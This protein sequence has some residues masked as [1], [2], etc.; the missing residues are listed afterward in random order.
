MRFRVSKIVLSSLLVEKKNLEMWSQNEIMYLIQIC[1]RMTLK[2]TYL[3]A[4]RLI[5]IRKSTCFSPKNFNNS[6]YSHENSV[7]SDEKINIRKISFITHFLWLFDWIFIF[8]F[9]FWMKGFFLCLL[10]LLRFCTI[11]ML[12][13]LKVWTFELYCFI[14]ITQFYF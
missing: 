1:N 5:F 11:C 9:F 6:N 14:I 7:D 3:N 8:K 13:N 10:L 4:N 2:F 12:N